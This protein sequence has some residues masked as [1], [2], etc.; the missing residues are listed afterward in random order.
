ML[1]SLNMRDIVLELC[2]SS[3]FGYLDLIVLVMC[4]NFYDIKIW[5]CWEEEFKAFTSG[6]IVF[7]PILN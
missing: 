1:H 6:M 4:M 5:M 3:E 2:G 7:G